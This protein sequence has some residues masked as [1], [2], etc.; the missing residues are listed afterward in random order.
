MDH[1]C[2]QV[3]DPSPLASVE[4]ART[5]GRRGVVRVSG[6]DIKNSDSLTKA[7]PHP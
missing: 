7:S 3:F 4:T 6:L 2:V 1:F 5:G